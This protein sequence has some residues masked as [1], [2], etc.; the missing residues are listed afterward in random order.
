MLRRGE[1][2]VQDLWRPVSR[3]TL[4]I[5]R[6]E[7]YER[8]FPAGWVIVADFDPERRIVLT[9]SGGKALRRRGTG[10]GER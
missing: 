5:F 3:S 9:E 2:R 7:A 10:I 4:R 1:A 8:R 6:A